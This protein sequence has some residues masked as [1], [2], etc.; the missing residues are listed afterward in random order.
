LK[1]IAKSC[2]FAALNYILQ[3]N[4]KRKGID[5]DQYQISFRFGFCAY[6]HL[7]RFG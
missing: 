6:A 1:R 4:L 5:H 7:T 3:A 2:L